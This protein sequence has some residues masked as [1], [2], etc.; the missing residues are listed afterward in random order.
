MARHANIDLCGYS[1]QALENFL[2][3]NPRIELEGLLDSL[4]SVETNLLCS[5]ISLDS[6]E[7][8]DLA[9]FHLFRLSLRK[10]KYK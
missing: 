8:H 1:P 3:N 7:L 9:T 4:E 10:L 2:L 5:A 6:R